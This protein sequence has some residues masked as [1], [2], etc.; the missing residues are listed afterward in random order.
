M[1]CEYENENGHCMLNE[2]LYGDF[3]FVDDSLYDTGRYCLCDNVNKE[4][5]DGKDNERL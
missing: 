3:L 2:C 1:K 4:L 5:E